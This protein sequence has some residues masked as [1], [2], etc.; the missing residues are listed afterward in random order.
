M[1]DVNNKK[2]IQKSDIILI[3]ILVIVITFT[4]VF[5]VHKVDKNTKKNQLVTLK[6]IS[7]KITVNMC[8]YFYNQWNSLDIAYRYIRPEN[9]ISIDN[10]LA[11]LG[12]AEVLC[13]MG[14]K[15]GI[16]LLID[17]EGYYYTVKSGKAALWNYSDRLNE[18][19]AA[20]IASMT[21]MKDNI[22]EYI[23]FSKK[24]DRPIITK[25]NV[26]ITHI[27]MAVDEKAFDIDLSLSEF[28]SITDAFVMR[29]NGRQ[30][31][32]QME[33]TALSKSYNLI[34]ALS[35]A[36]Y[37]MGDSYSE[38]KSLIKSEKSGSAII[39]YKGVVYFL[40]LHYMGIEDWYAVFIVNSHDMTNDVKDLSYNLI[41]VIAVSSLI[42]LLITVLLLLK[43]R[44]QELKREKFIQNYL[45]EAALTADKANEAKSVF[46]SRMSHDIRTPI[47]GIIGMTAIALSRTDDK[48]AVKSCLK[49]I[50]AASDH[51]LEL[52]NEVL[53]I[54]RIESGTIVL[55]NAP[56]NLTDMLN[57]INDIVEG[58]FAEKNLSYVPNFGRLTMPYVN[59]CES[60]L[61]QIL[62]NILGNA[63]K[64]TD[65]GGKISFT[66]F[67]DNECGDHCTYHF[68]IEDNGI[69]MIPEY[70]E[71]IFE[72][73]SQEKISAR[74]HYEGT[75][76]GLSIVK[77]LTEFLGGEVTVS[78]ELGVGSTFEVIIPFE[79]LDKEAFHP[80]EEEPAADESRQYQILLAEDNETNREVAEFLLTSAGM[81]CVSVENGAL[82][83]ETFENSEI[84]E[85]DALLMDIMMPEMD[86][87][88]ATRIIRHMERAD[89]L[90]IP[91]FAMTANAYK[92]DMEK[93]LAAGM[94]THLTKPIMVS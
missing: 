52:V 61:K 38:I 22:D 37:I 93:S 2:P 66:V 10:L 20:F 60:L 89:A 49:K 82:A 72:R 13:N 31:N 4:F 58:K 80:A 56:L 48:E 65:D 32:S 27:I 24:L 59:G 12:E 44:K 92:E 83:V 17:S 53:D 81:S 88:E 77:E 1:P 79:Q 90:T 69:G 25:E 67:N 42:I 55:E 75:G 46:L 29:S 39:R 14:S 5:I 85:Y 23:C 16:M 19:R 3:I 78:S 62:I 40:S 51:L 45:R 68:I 47:N 76:L 35:D 7:D 50:S 86:G 71:H 9:H 91:I 64:Y 94:N 34:D 8:D 21:E 26:T 36:K 73:F 28:G 57:S 74:T 41:G 87:L 30:I 54:S 84:G 11:G 70:L 18:P 63:T 6:S 33:N 43:N 15:R